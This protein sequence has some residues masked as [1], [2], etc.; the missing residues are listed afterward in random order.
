VKKIKQ[1]VLSPKVYAKEFSSINHH[2]KGFTKVYKIPPDPNL[3]I[4]SFLFFSVVIKV[5]LHQ[6]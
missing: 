2:S 1:K 4:H 6:E 5:F 3:S